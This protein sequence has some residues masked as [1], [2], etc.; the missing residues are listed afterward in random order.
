MLNHY[1]VIQSTVT[2]LISYRLLSINQ[3]KNEKS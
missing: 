1:Y 2:F 3:L